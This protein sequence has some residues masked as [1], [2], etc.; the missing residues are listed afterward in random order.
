M[1]IPF[2]HMLQVSDSTFPIGAFAL[3][4]GLE[5]FVQERLLA[6][7][8]DLR[9]YIDSTLSFLPYTELGFFAHIFHGSQQAEDICAVDN[10]YSAYK[11]PLEV[12]KGSMK[13]CQRFLKLWE[14]IEPI[15]ILAT[16]QKCIQ[17]RRCM[18][19]YCIALALFAKSKNLTYA[20]AASMYAY[21]I[22]SAIVTNAVKNVPLS[23]FD[24]QS[25]LN[26][27]LPRIMDCVQCAQD[28]SLE[29]LGMGGSAFDIYAMRHETLYS[30]LYMS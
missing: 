11:T 21:T 26:A 30:R 1:Q 2:L 16:Y 20:D 7:C 4:N 24:G 13:L 8:D 29:E 17:E 6:S 28:V 14:R 9:E 18:G 12:R 19:H 3:S 15:P 22:L 25:V 5:T 10:L 27:A 23:Q